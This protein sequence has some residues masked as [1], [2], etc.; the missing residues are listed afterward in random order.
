[1]SFPRVTPSFLFALL[2]SCG[3]QAGN[4]PAGPQ[5]QG[6]AGMVASAGT[7]SGA[8]GSQASGGS[9][10]MGGTSSNT[11]GT[12]NPATG[13][14]PQ[15]SG[16]SAGVSGSSGGAVATGGMLATGGV[17][18]AG[19]AG[20][21]GVGG[22]ASGGVPSDAGAGGD[23]PKGGADSADA[24]IVPDPSWACGMAD[25]VPP[26]TRGKL[27]FRASLELGETNDVG[28]V[29]YGYRRVRHVVGGTLMG[30]RVQGTVLTGGL[31][32]ELELST[33]SIELEQINIFRTSDGTLIFMRTC[34]F[35]PAGDDVTRIVPDLEV[36]NSSSLSWLNT[37]KFAGTR[38]VDEAAKTIELAVYDVSD[39]AVTEP[40]IQIKDPQGVAQQPWEC[41]KLT[42]SRG[43]AVFTETVTLGSSLSVGQSKRGN[44]N[45]IPITGGTVSGRVEGKVLSGGGDYQSNAGL[46]AK[47]ILETNDGE[48]IVIRNCGP[49]GALIP[50]FE[51]RVDGPYAFL[52]ANNFLSS[53]PGGAPGGVSIT[54]YERQ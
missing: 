19:G 8:G 12:S 48:F 37:G 30:D 34:G 47:Y 42:G 45:I 53:D 41:A 51:A 44:R 13:G 40:K 50:Q 43:A 49:F 4:E 31:D 10:S 28:E 24:T 21:G 22:S 17:L 11:G 7:S 36:A 18:A 27:V 23:A 29:Q 1:M 32:L 33:G 38:V 14:A 25:G 46:D 2:L 16:G 15:T 54:F 5:A 20:S 9:P 52:N 26:P 35:A 6:A 39:V 3:E